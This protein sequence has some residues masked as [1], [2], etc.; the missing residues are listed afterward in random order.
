MAPPS[1]A[2]HPLR[3][4]LLFM[5]ALML[6]ALLDATS[7]HLTATFAVPLLVWARYTLHFA[8]ML[9]FVAPSMRLQ[10]VRTDN[11]A[12]Q[13]VRALALVGTTGFA[14]MAFRSMPLAE[15]TAVLFLSP[16][17]VTLLAGPF[18]GERIGAGRW[19]AVV[20]G[21]A[22]VILIA[23]PGGALT[24]AGVLWALAGAACYA[25]YQLLTRRLS[26]AEHPLTLLFYTALVG[27]AVMSLALPWFWFE[28]SPSPL[29]WLQIASLGFYGGV[30]HFILIRAF[31]LA[32]ASTLTPFGYTQLIWAGLLGWLVFGHIPDALSA[33]G[34]AVI[35]AS[36]LWLALG[37][38]R[39]PDQ[40]D[41]A[42]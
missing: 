7:K 23:R 9:V 31:R 5:L 35:A 17:L 11:L 4:I 33:A 26:H 6:F 19:A 21:F 39:R 27:T 25:A 38:R 18:L 36:G 40:A 42:G 1:P 41:A 22:G 32:P 12:L 13:I 20:V 2:Q 15:A 14:M 28:F 24:L 37:E 29:Q 3:G 16:L 30:G 8:I 34:M 10:L